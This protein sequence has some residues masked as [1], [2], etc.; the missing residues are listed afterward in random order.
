[1][2]RAIARSCAN[3]RW[4]DIHGHYREAQFTQT[5]HHWWWKANWIFNKIQATQ[6]F[7]GFEIIYTKFLCKQS[8]FDNICHNTDKNSR[9]SCL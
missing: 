6:H 1:M 2:F 7:S 4:P 8:C 9:K 5:K 3:A